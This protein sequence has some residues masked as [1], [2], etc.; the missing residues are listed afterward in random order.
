MV[1]DGQVS[2]LAMGLGKLLN[3]Q[4]QKEHPGT[5]QFNSRHGLCKNV[6]KMYR[7]GQE[8]SVQCNGLLCKRCCFI[9][10]TSPVAAVP[11]RCRGTVSE[12]VRSCACLIMPLM[13]SRMHHTARILGGAYAQPAP[14]HFFACLAELQYAFH[15]CCAN[16]KKHFNLK[17]VL[18]LCVRDRGLRMRREVD[19]LTPEPNACH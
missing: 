4:L 10:Q 7:S 12:P 18:E 16:K 1:S 8:S 17:R 3:G 5:W 11:W 9:A 15:R 2:G 13:C 19:G 14:C 6:L